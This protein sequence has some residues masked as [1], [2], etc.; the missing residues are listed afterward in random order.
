MTTEMLTLCFAA[1]PSPNGEL[2]ILGATDIIFV[3]QFPIA[4]SCSLVAKLRFRKIE[5][6]VKEILFSIIDS[7]GKTLQPSPPAQQINIQIPQGASSASAAIVVSLHNLQVPRAGEY[8]LGLAVNGRL[9][10]TVPL[11]IRQPPPQPAP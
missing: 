3:P 11:F 4:I 2:N 5:E 6:G 10:M 7:D 9:E 1:R 8:E